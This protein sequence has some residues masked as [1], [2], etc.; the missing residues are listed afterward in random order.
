[1]A[2]LGEEAAGKKQAFMAENRM[3]YLTS[4]VQQSGNDKLGLWH[5][6]CRSRA[7]GEHDPELNASNGNSRR[8]HP[9]RVA[10]L[11][12]SA[13]HDLRSRGT[14]IAA[15]EP[16]AP[17][18]SAGVGNDYTGWE[19]YRSTNV[20]IGSI[21]DTFGPPL[22]SGSFMR[23]DAPMPTKMWWRPDKVVA[24]YSL[25]S[26]YISGGIRP[27]WCT[28]GSTTTMGVDWWGWFQFT[29]P[30]ECWAKCEESP[31]CFSAVYEVEDVAAG[32][33]QCWIGP[34]IL[35][36][37]PDPAASRDPSKYNATCYSKNVT[38]LPVKIREE[39]F[40]ALNEVVSTTITA[41]RQVTLEIKGG[42]YTS[43]DLNKPNQGVVGGLTTLNGTC[44]HELLD[45]ELDLIRI[46][47][48]G[49]AEASVLPSV[50]REGPF[51]LDGTSGVLAASR[52]MDNL[53]L[54][55][56][57]GWF[58]KVCEYQFSTVIGGTAGNTTLAYSMEDSDKYQNTA[59]RVAVVAKNPKAEAAA[60]THKMNGLLNDVVPYFRCSDE[61]IVKVYY[62]LWSVYL[63]LYIDVGK[64]LE[65]L[66]H[67][68]SAANNFL[69]MH[70]FDAV[71]QIMV[72]ER[73]REGEGERRR[74][75]R[76]ILLFV[77]QVG[78]WTNPNRHDFYA[79]GNVLNWHE[80]LKRGLNAT[81]MLPDNYG[82]DWGSAV[83][84]HEALAHILGAL[85]IYEHSGDKDYLRKAYAFYKDLYWDNMFWIENVFGQ[86]YDA[87]L[88]LNKM[89]DILGVPEDAS[90]W[91]ST[92][93][94]TYRTSD[95]YINRRD[96]EWNQ[97]STWDV[98][99]NETSFNW[100]QISGLGQSDVK[101]EFVEK[102]GRVWLID[103]VYGHWDKVP[104]ASIPLKVSSLSLS[105][106][107]SVFLPF[108]LPC[109]SATLIHLSFPH[110]LSYRTITRMTILKATLNVPCSVHALVESIL[111]LQSF[112]MLTSG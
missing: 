46:D 87:V 99:N 31:T 53:T 71:F 63:M 40:I 105:R 101:R 52:P 72:R 41:D 61:E 67:T 9:P 30:S 81:N 109:L 50:K 97:T 98:M 62:F 42:S 93:G 84:G 70:R 10:R 82:I 28:S 38:I 55:S 58:G 102:M 111:T 43:G 19:W 66:P 73:G 17:E 3:Y 13:V 1:M 83:Y 59:Q 74:L 108:P 80:V 34:N 44:S 21:V 39:K 2:W 47:E 54:T 64:G 18:P 15:Y 79:H 89:A 88:A 68:Q 16:A 112:P 36:Q 33:T 76:S 107:L 94:M 35:T 57:D 95:F 12:H 22:P 8:C 60:K 24:E 37:A 11:C 7:S 25:S 86:G 32:K 103:P 90:H 69:G 110:C 14:G 75:T 56:R 91:N 26:P 5:P 51:V 6:Y 48:T 85:D 77:F 78:A 100:L 49:R 20:A 4:G 104:L 96:K 27:G 45:G 106:F 29:D 92:S 23:W 65:K